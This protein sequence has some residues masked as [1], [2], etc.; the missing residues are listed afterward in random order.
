MNSCCVQFY[1]EEKSQVTLGKLA[2]R[3]GENAD[4]ASGGTP[5]MDE[6]LDCVLSSPVLDFWPSCWMNFV[7]PT[8]Y[9]TS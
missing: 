3:N 5:P 2:E 4:P 6:L 7:M 8:G 9:S 1:L